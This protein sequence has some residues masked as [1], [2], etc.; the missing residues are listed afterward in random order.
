[1]KTS[2]HEIKFLIITLV[3]ALSIFALHAL[4]I[5]P[6]LGLG[7]GVGGDESFHFNNVA[8]FDIKKP[9]FIPRV[10]DPLLVK[11]LVKYER[12]K[13]INDNFAHQ[14]FESPPDEAIP[15][16]TKLKSEY[17]YGK[18][19]Y[20]IASLFFNQANYKRSLF[21]I[22]FS[23]LFYLV[24]GLLF[25]Y[26]IFK[27]VLGTVG[28]KLPTIMLVSTYSLYGYV[29]IVNPDTAV[30][31]F[32]TAVSYFVIKLINHRNSHL[33]LV[34][35][36]T[37][38]ILLGLVTKQNVSL[39]AVALLSSCL[40]I[41]NLTLISKNRG[42]TVRFSLLSLG[43]A[44]FVVLL[45]LRLRIIPEFIISSLQTFRPSLLT[46]P[47]IYFSFAKS[48]LEVNTVYLLDRTLT[49]PVYFIL[50]SLYTLAIL[51]L[52]R[53]LRTS[54]Q[55]KTHDHLL[56]LGLGAVIYFA[57]YGLFGFL[58]FLKEG[59]PVL[60]TRHLIPVLPQIILLLSIGLSN[61]SNKELPNKILTATPI[62]LFT[63]LLVRFIFLYFIPRYYL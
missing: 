19:Y 7:S 20:F 42:K 2:R 1:M 51:G 49:I 38:F 8:L 57:V 45:V 32:S 5:P 6:Y 22:R 34:V 23:N 36:T 55:C 12:E 14:N 33:K 15:P 39:Y 26:L 4:L 44:A 58:F 13:L 28:A 37:V 53:K 59:N 63:L 61:I 40:V 54:D 47:Q 16:D 50:A 17:N 31:L 52:V 35:V 25:S 27:T 24:G 29:S 48:F 3:Y 46:N 10:W 18:L 30:F 43:I 9:L 62:V 41:K 60:N 56:I 21:N 11:E